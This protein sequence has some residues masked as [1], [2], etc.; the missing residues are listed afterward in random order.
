[1]VLTAAEAL[2]AELMEQP[3]ITGFLIQRAVLIPGASA[4]LEGII[5]MRLW[6]AQGLGPAAVEVELALINNVMEATAP[7]ALSWS[8]GR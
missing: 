7:R 3:V 2:P 8:N 1:M 4:V 5:Q 6:L